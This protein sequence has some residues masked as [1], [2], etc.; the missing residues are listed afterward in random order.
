MNGSEEIGLLRYQ[1]GLLYKE[2]LFLFQ[3]F[4]IYEDGRVG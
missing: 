1:F 3:Y 2:E 4:A